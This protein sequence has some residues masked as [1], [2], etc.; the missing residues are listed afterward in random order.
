[1]PKKKKEKNPEK[2]EI[3]K[4]VNG[5]SSIC[6]LLSIHVSSFC[7]LFC[8]LFCYKEKNVVIPYRLACICLKPFYKYL[9]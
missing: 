3:L 1:M 5:I 7:E 9:N 2:W 8:E 4:N 6:W